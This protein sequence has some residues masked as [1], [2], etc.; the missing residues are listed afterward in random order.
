GIT[1]TFS[2]KGIDLNVLFQGQFGNDIYN[3]GGPYMSANG[4]FFDNQTRDQLNSWKKVGDITNVPQARFYGGNGTA[5]SS[6][7]LQRGDFVRLRTLTLGYALPKSI[8]S[9]LK[10]T[11][12]RLYASAVNLLTFTKYTGWDPEVNSDASTGNIALGNDFYSAPQARTITG[13]LQIGF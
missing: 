4:D 5:A 12:I 10:M 9:R 7:Y 3:G 6:R 8:V 2:Y 11:R 13:G 1:N